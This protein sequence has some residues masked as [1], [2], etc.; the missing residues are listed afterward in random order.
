[1]NCA[2]S[3]KE[4]GHALGGGFCVCAFVNPIAFIKKC[5]KP[6]LLV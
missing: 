3:G 2:S 5:T 1:M 6:K 4:P